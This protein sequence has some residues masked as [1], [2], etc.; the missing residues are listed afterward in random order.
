M[1]LNCLET[2]YRR[3]ML[4]EV[5]KVIKFFKEDKNRLETMPVNE[6][7]YSGMYDYGFGAIALT[8][9]FAEYTAFYDEQSSM[10]RATGAIMV[11]QEEIVKSVL[12][13]SSSSNSKGSG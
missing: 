7:A 2:V 1:Q 13:I 5:Q 8:M 11:S 12:E 10:A 3:V 6:I 4:R 9:S